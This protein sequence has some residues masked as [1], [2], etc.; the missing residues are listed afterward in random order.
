MNIMQQYYEIKEKYTDYLLFFRIGEFYELFEEDAVIASK[1][2]HIA[3]TKRKNK[4][5]EV[6]MAG[7]PFS[8][9]TIHISNLVKAGCKIALCEQ[10]QTLDKKEK[11]LERKVIKIITS[12]TF[13]EEN[14]FNAENNNYLISIIFKN[15]I[16]Y[17]CVLD[18]STSQIYIE[19]GKCIEEFLEKTNPKEVLINLFDKEKL[20]SIK[21]VKDK[22]TIIQEDSSIDNLKN[23]MSFYN[24]HTEKSIEYLNSE[25]KNAL[26]VI[27]KYLQFTQ[28]TSTHNISLPRII[29][30]N[31]KLYIDKYTRK[32]LEIIK[33]LQ[34]ESKGSLL[35][36]LNHTKTTQGSR[37]L[38]NLLNNPTNN[39]A[40]CRRI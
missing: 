2:L 13:I 36:F 34:G 21:E 40:K 20:Q 28:Q 31:D 6:P 22:I 14:Y 19:S 9:S 30:N 7:I 4:G 33:T 35:W 23:I 37:L 25:Q 12:G 8:S 17:S 1:T 29:N 39:R 5:K 16:F 27:I 24:L 26:N 32:N 15:N 3:L 10:V 18:L 38:V 11:I